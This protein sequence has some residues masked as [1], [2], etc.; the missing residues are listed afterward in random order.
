[1]NLIRL[2]VFVLAVCFTSTGFA[3]SK[4]IKTDG[5]DVLTETFLRPLSFMGMVGGTG[6]FV[7]LSPLTALASI[8]SLK[9]DAFEELADTLIV[10][11][12]KYTFVR[13]L[14]DYD[15]NEGLKK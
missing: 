3:E 15:Y 11:P 13:P 9:S 7:I 4:A 10:K 14:G 12:Y 8:P 1:M 2:A 6:A 5:Y